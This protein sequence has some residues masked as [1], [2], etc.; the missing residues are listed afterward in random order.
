MSDAKVKSKPE[1]VVS[2]WAKPFWEGTAEGKLVLQRCNDCSRHIFYP[3]VICPHCSSENVE[4]QQVSG[5]GKVY[6]FT[7][8]QNNAPSAFTAEMP[9]VVAVIEL[10]E[11]VRMLSNV[12]DCDFEQL[13][14]DMPVSVVFER[15]NDEFVLPKFRPA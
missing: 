10:D 6:S 8:V 2:P 9:Y 12:I 15:L 11:G 14:C 1:P 4:W 7:Q 5:K 13:S 3:R